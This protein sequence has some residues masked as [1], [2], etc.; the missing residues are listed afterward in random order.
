MTNQIGTK[1]LQTSS[2]THHTPSQT[3]HTHQYG[4]Q[5]HIHN[6]R[7]YRDSQK[8]SVPEAVIHP[9]LLQQQQ[10]LLLSKAFGKSVRSP[11]AS[12][13]TAQSFSFRLCSQLHTLTFPSS[14]ETLIILVASCLCCH[15]LQLRITSR[16]CTSHVGVTLRFDSCYS[17]Q[18][19]F[20]LS[21][22]T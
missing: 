17:H 22:M 3:S 13:L 4:N 6:S 10:L 19:P 21:R 5:I 7:A 20:S 1:L 12:Q 9:L 14:A 18:T 2:Q 8:E 11:S 15:T 16:G